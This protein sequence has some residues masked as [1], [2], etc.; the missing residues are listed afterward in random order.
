MLAWTFGYGM[1]T[2]ISAAIEGANF[3]RQRYA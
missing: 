2:A 3:L 1:S